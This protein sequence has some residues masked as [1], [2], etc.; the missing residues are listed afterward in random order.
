MDCCI[1]ERNGKTNPIDY[2]IWGSVGMRFIVQPYLK[3]H[4]VSLCVVNLTDK[5][6]LSFMLREDA[7]YFVSYNHIESSDARS[8]LI[9]LANEH[10][11][12]KGPMILLREFKAY[13]VEIPPY[14]ATPYD[15]DMIKIAEHESDDEHM[16]RLIASTVEVDS[17]E[18]NIKR[19]LE[20]MEF[21]Q[22]GMISTVI[23]ADFCDDSDVSDDS[24]DVDDGEVTEY[25]CDYDL[26]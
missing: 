1:V 5:R 12:G 11:M 22:S 3:C 13:R 10:Q 19:T 18:A 25:S 9:R 6:S 2:I 21:K 16:K 26:N 15:I 17:M 20:E 23:D 4:N 8:T 7:Q 24:W 14:T